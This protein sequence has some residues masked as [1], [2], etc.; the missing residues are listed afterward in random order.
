MSRTLT[1]QDNR[2]LIASF[3]N[4]IESAVKTA[5]CHMKDGAGSRPEVVNLMLAFIQHQ[6]ERAQEFK[7]PN[8][9]ARRAEAARQDAAL[10]KLLK[11]ASKPTPIRATTGKGA[12]RALKGGAA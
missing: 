8:P 6:A 7:W 1:D 9:A 11:R 5:R 4:T 12:R 2:E 10:Q 3:F